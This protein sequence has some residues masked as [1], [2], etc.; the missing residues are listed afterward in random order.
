MFDQCKEWFHNRHD[1][2]REWKARGRGKVLGYFCSYAPEEI[3]YAAGALPV[4]ILGAHETEDVTER[5]IVGMYCPF[6]RDVLAQG[7]LGRY[8]Y[9]DGI[10]LSQSC[11]HL[12][13]SFFSWKLHVPVEFAHNILMPHGTQ[14]PQAVPYLRDELQEFIKALENWTGRRIG[15]SDLEEGA[16]LINRNRQLMQQIYEWRKG[17]Q[18]KLTGLEAMYMVLS[19]QVTDKREHNQELER[20][21]AE[22][23]N[24]RIDRP[25]GIRL[26][27]VGSENDDVA[28]VEMVETN[29]STVV[30]DEHCTGSRYFWNLVD[31]DRGRDIL[32]RI[33]ERY[34]KRPACPS[35]DWPK[36]NR[37][38]HIKQLAREYGAE[39]ALLIQQKF[40]DPHELEIPAL[41]AELEAE[42]I[43]TYMF[44]FDTTVPVG[45]FKI[46]F[47]AF[48]EVLKSEELPF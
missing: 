9:L 48:M 11:L 23:P 21:L 16:A 47:E 15:D 1:Y 45:Q 37:F 25:T 40:C 4:R 19:S 43:K 31:G 20:I 6:C 42:G 24:R 10:T 12:R 28:F 26:I 13:Q 35:K 46:R 7:L 33:A 44:E 36:R 5:H 27:M 3:I 39:A 18:P 29:G 41:R 8:G 22:L 2:A 14:T 17:S 32:T 30:I 34:V 38:P